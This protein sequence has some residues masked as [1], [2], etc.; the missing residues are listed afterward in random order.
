[1]LIAL[2]WFRHDFRAH[3]DPGSLQQAVVFVPVYLL[4]VLVFTAITLFAERHHITPDLT[5][6]GNV[7]PPT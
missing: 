3:S 4:C 7:I 5:F 6:W 1:M 2:I